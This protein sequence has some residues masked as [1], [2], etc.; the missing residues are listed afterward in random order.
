MKQGL[1]LAVPQFDLQK[2]VNERT[3]YVVTQHDISKKCCSIE[4]SAP[5][6]FILDV[7]PF[8][9][10]KH[11]STISFLTGLFYLCLC[12]IAA[13]VQLQEELAGPSAKQ[14]CV[15]PKMREEFIG[16]G[17]PDPEKHVENGGGN[18]ITGY[19]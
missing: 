5:S 19:T 15:S 17:H 6:G 9:K 1:T 11:H 16:A 2:K 8:S 12:G 18:G 7:F 4:V 10:K 3:G 13:I 14:R